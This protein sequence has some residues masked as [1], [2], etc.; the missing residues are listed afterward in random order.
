M[1]KLTTD[2]HYITSAHPDYHLFE[3]NPTEAL[4]RITCHSYHAP[5]SVSMAEL[6]P[7]KEQKTETTAERMLQFQ[8]AINL[9]RLKRKCIPLS[10]VG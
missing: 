9:D 8:A 6:S 7:V 1:T 10:R 3:G 4:S 5:A 2:K